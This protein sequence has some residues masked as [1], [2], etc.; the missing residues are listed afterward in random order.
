MKI[1]QMSSKDVEH[2]YYCPECLLKSKTL[3]NLENHLLTEHFWDFYDTA[4]YISEI[5]L[6]D[7]LR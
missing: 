7:N 3:H 5:E 4:Y 2:F 6:R 1:T